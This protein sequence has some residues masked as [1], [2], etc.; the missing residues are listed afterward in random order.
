MNKNP[1]LDHQIKNTYWKEKQQKREVKAAREKK[2]TNIFYGHES[3]A[4]LF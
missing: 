3:W 1:A 4:T 2:Q